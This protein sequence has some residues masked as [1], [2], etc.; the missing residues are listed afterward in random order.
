MAMVPMWVFS[1]SFGHWLNV[2]VRKWRRSLGKCLPL[3]NDVIMLPSALVCILFEQS[4]VKRNYSL[5]SNACWCHNNESHNYSQSS[6]L[7]YGF[8]HFLTPRGVSFMI[9]VELSWRLL[10]HLLLFSYNGVN[11]VFLCQ[12]ENCSTKQKLES[13]SAIFK[14]YEP[15]LLVTTRWGYEDWNPPISSW[16]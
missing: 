5:L 12:T 3:L 10:V 7:R 14:L 13:F 1:V 4:L 6:P 15:R 11:L 2:A 16:L 8:Q 9:C